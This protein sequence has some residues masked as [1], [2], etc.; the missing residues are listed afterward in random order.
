M[1][2]FYHGHLLLFW[3]PTWGI[4]RE[5]P[6]CAV[7]IQGRTWFHRRSQPHGHFPVRPLMPR[8]RER[9]DLPLDAFCAKP[10]SACCHACVI[11]LTFAN[12]SQAG[13]VDGQ[14]RY[15]AFGWLPIGHI[16]QHPSVVRWIGDG[17]PRRHDVGGADST[18]CLITLG[19]KWAWR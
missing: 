2:A 16:T 7:S 4:V 11:P 10:G 12:H 13:G 15:P 14:V 17:R 5:W 1:Q 18:C 9:P 19:A 6:L 3:A 8:C